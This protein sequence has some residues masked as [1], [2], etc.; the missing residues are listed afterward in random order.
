[1]GVGV[2]SE[3]ASVAIR[4]LCADDEAFVFETWLKGAKRSTY[5]AQRIRDGV[6]YRQHHLVIERI[7]ERDPV[8]LIAHTTDCPDVILGYVIAEKAG[9]LHWGDSPILHWCYVKLPWRKLGIATKL[10][11]KATEGNPERAVFTH[12][13]NWR[14]S[15]PAPKHIDRGDHRAIRAAK[16]ELIARMER[17]GTGGGDTDDLLRKWPGMVFDPYCW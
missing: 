15:V 10:I 16:K 14:L 5:H 4:P 8:A 11:E 7:L 9:P 2:A 17:D 12:W 13:T 1:M 3:G 6:F